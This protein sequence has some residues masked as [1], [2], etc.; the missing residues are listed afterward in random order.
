MPPATQDGRARRLCQRALARRIAVPGIFW[1]NL[2]DM[3]AVTKI[4][5]PTLS[6]HEGVPGHLTAGA[7]ANA[8]P[9]QPLLLQL[10]SF[11]AYN[12]GWAVY[13]RADDGRDRRLCRRIRGAISAASTTSCSAQSGSSSTPACT[14]C[15]GRAA[16]AIAVMAEAT[17]DAMSEVTAE[18][19]RYMAWPGA[20]A[21]LQARPAPPAVAAREDARRDMGA[22]F[23]LRRFH[24]AVLG[25]G[26]LPLDLVAIEVTRLERSAP[27]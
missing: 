22:R 8:L 25:R 6:Y 3:A 14:S 21:R 16:Q 19:E 7:V 13:W 1:I 20:G 23:D 26:N 10:A 27:V 2:R 11:N 9:K 12:E 17:G 15:A 18:I 4:A 24:R 5:L